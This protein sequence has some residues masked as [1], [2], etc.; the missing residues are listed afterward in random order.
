MSPRPPRPRAFRYRALAAGLAALLI[1][2]L[3][4]CSPAAPSASAPA[5]TFPPLSALQ[6][7]ADPRGW[8]G[9]STAVLDTAAIEPVVTD[10]AQTL[11]ASVVSHDG[12]GDVPTTIRDT[13]RVITMDLAGSLAATVQGLGLG[14]LLVGRDQS[15]SFPGVEG[16]PVVTGSGHTVNA[17]K[18]ISLAPTLIL[19]DGSIGP[20][21]VVEQ[22]RDVGITVV[23]L[24]NEPSFDGASR[25]ARDVAAALGVPEAGERL[26][27]R[28]ADGIAAARAEIQAVAPSD[29]ARKVRMIFLY[30]RGSVGIYYLFGA[31]S[32]ADAL[33]SALGGVDVAGE[34]GWK[35]MRPMTD[36]AM[37][38][39][40]PDL[41]LVMTH[42]LASAGGVDALLAEKPAIALTSAGQHRRFVDMDDAQILSFGPRSAEVLTALARAVYAPDATPREGS[43]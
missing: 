28:I 5:P 38:A 25:L 31:E 33:I 9:P 8:D 35:G 16:L 24:R 13:S 17:E 12:S 36:E 14:G 34:Q 2:G 43:R 11:P 30:V 41:V 26:A 3:T 22:L 7:V 19:T 10:P 29:P 32:G 6:P 27:A 1:A 39:A 37:A 18:I 23:F 42:G 21:D 40:D 15:T 4:A 20:R